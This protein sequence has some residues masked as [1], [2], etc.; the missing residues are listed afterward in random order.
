MIF[1]NIKAR[2]RFCIGLLYFAGENT[3]KALGKKL[4]GFADQ[5]NFMKHVNHMGFKLD[6]NE[7][8]IDIQNLDGPDEEQEQKSEEQF[9]K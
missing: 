3:D 5:L 7:K 6:S 2:C 9:D 4:T 8:Q 1:S